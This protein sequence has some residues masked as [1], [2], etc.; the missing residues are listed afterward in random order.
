MEKNHSST[1]YGY[2]IYPYLNVAPLFVTYEKK[3]DKAS[4]INYEDH[5]NN[6]NTF[7][8]FS[9]NKLNIDSSEI[10]ALLNVLN[11][12]GHVLLFIKKEDIKNSKNDLNSF[13]FV[14]EC[15]LK[16]YENAKMQSEASVVK[17][18]FNLKDSVDLTLYKYLENI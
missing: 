6:P 14:G 2:K 5:F 1:I 3:L 17:F 11:N 12:N 4:S 13:Y 8:W 10:K 16:S 9:R 7:T 18:I 15:I